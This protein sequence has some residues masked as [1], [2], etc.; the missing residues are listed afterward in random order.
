MVKIPKKISVMSGS[1]QRRCLRG[2]VGDGAGVRDFHD[3]ASPDRTWMMS[4]T[5]RRMPPG[6]SLAHARVVSPGAAPA[7]HQ[8]IAVP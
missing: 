3:S 4:S 2:A 7:S 1:H 8:P 5:P 6:I